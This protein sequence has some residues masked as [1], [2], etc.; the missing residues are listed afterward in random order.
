[1]HMAQIVPSQQLYMTM[2]YVMSVQ[3]L[4]LCVSD[5]C[6]QALPWSLSQVQQEKCNEALNLH[7]IAAAIAQYSLEY[8]VVGVVQWSQM[9][10]SAN[11]QPRSEA[12]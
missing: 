12:P 6:L 1:M 3:L 7:F 4:L 8:H 5:P 2:H 9:Q 11:Q 10:P